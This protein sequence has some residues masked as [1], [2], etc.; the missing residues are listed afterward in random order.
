MSAF[1]PNSGAKA[2]RNILRITAA[3]TVAATLAL[4]AFAQTPPPASAPARQSAPP[5]LVAQ[6][7]GPTPAKPYHFPP[8]ASKTLANGLRVFVVSSPGMPVVT[9][10]LV[11]TS[12]GTVNDPDGRPGVAQM[13]AG[14][15][16]QGTANRTAQQIAESI[17]FVGGSLT[18]AADHDG[19]VVSV[20]VVKKD[21]DLAMDLFSDV[22]LHAA[23]QQEELE[24]QR[25]Q[26]LSN[27]S[28]SYNDPEY[29]ASAVFQRA[30]FGMHPYG[31]PNDGTP[32]SIRAITR[33]DLIAFRDTFYSPG[34]ALLA[35]S[36][37]IT[38]EAAFAA[39]EK[40]FGAWQGKQAAPA[41][42]PAAGAGAGVHIYVVDRADA[43]Q[44]QIRIGRIGLRRN[45]PDFIPLFVADRIFGGSYNSRLNTEVR[46]KKGL[47]YGA[48]TVFDARLESGVLEASTFTRTEATMDAVKLVVN[49]LQG[50]SK[51]DLKPE[52][53]S[54]AKD[55]LIG[56]YPIQTETPE[57]VA[58]R[59]LTVAHYGLPADYN[60]TYQ[61]RIS[62]VTLAQA[63]AA[64][65]KYYQ[66]A[67]L[68]IVLAG[69]A[70]QF[71]D[72]LKKEFPNATYEEIPPNQLDLLLPGM[73]RKPETVPPATPE[74]LAQ[75][76]TMF[77]R[78]VQAVGGA[79]IGKVQSIECAS[80]GTVDIGQGQATTI[81]KVTILYPN[82]FRVDTELF[83]G[84]ADQGMLTR[85]YDGKMGW[86]NFPMQ[87]QGAVAVPEPQNV[88]FIRN[89]LLAG[90]WGLYRAALQG[91]AIQAQS[92]GQRD[93]AGNKTDA[94]AIAIGDV[95]LI[96]YLDP[97]T[98]LVMGVRYMQDIQ[99]GKVETVEVW[100]DYRDVEGMKFPFHRVTL[101]AGQKFS[102]DE[103]QQVKI[104]V[105]P[106][107]KLFVKP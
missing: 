5:T 14:L 106:D 99:G 34:K 52:E 58:G 36:G 18:T 84:G 4:S 72:S 66:T 76:K 54:F 30:V 12:A 78:A 65:M 28:V 93:F 19:T 85:G 42:H 2:V 77:T 92:I 22:T 8:V 96:A 90:G 62:N 23:F 86:L 17:D 20:T 27:L 9:A 41:N 31:L 81:Q 25:Q 46:I 40:F 80:A 33:N 64:A 103:L 91:E 57:E 102:E 10:R 38:P 73:R 51:G 26:V 105:N 32:T 100:T 13:V 71:R 24:R 53:L 43:V 87:G 101:R 50:M 55:Y 11:I 7:P 29:L 35:F 82:H 47:T 75:G 68:D 49:L 88:E 44:T 39:A 48:N 59:V 104:N 45:D 98:G 69:N 79:A 97:A 107:V 61:T 70:A 3:F 21:F 16:T 67:S 95:Q 6:M 1:H 60:E 15:L 63:N 89:I 83:V 37:D 74:S 56:V 94:M